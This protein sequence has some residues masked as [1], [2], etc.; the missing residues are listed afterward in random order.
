MKDRA[1]V[2]VFVLLVCTVMSVPVMAQFDF[3]RMM[4]GAAKLVKAVTLTDEQMAEYVKNMLLRWMR[5]IRFVRI[6]MYIPSD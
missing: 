1:F 5:R 6:I 4:S 3:N 2:K